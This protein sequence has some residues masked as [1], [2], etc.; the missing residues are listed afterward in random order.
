MNLTELTLSLSLLGWMC[1]SQ[2]LWSVSTCLI[3]GVLIS[4][5]F[6]PAFDSTAYH[7]MRQ[8]N[9]WSYLFFHAGNVGI[10]FLPAFFTLHFPPADPVFWHGILAATTHVAWTFVASGFTFDISQLGRVY[11]PLRTTHW[12]QL[13][14]IGIVAELCAPV[15]MLAFL[16]STGT[17]LAMPS[18]SRS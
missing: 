1:D 18:E 5:S 2:I 14:A 12:V 6:A 13:S 10:H 11:V 8:K 9:G 16:H 15:A 3:W 7:R 4:F 17:A